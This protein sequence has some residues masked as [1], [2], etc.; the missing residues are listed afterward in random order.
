VSANEQFRL[1]VEDVLGYMQ[2][3]LVKLEYIEPT[4]RD[5]LYRLIHRRWPREL[6]RQ[7]YAIRKRN[8]DIW[9]AYMTNYRAGRWKRD[10]TSP[11]S[12]RTA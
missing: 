11:S 7:E 2:A 9:L 12:E 8:A 1:G 3:G 6:A 10:A 4:W 5:R